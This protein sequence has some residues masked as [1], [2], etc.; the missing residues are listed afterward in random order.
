[1]W[2]CVCEETEY[3]ERNER[4]RTGEGGD[5]ERERALSCALSGTLKLK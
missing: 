3:K 4:M 2:V 5:Y 1:M